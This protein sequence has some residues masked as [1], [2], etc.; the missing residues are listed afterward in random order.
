MVQPKERVIRRESVRYAVAVLVRNGPRAVT[1]HVAPDEVVDVVVEKFHCMLEPEKVARG[2]LRRVA[3]KVRA[4]GA[5]LG[6]LMGVP[7]GEDRQVPP[8]LV[9]YR[10]RKLKAP[11]KRTGG[12]G[13]VGLRGGVTVPRPAQPVLGRV[14]EDRR[15][16]EVGM[17]ARPVPIRCR[18][19]IPASTTQ[20][21]IE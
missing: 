20:R 21:G 14:L 2:L 3:H 17:V 1:P 13:A 5:V 11:S 12:D 18:S 15:D 8:Q 7:A 9:S 10:P 16:E 6:Q 4:Q 19:T